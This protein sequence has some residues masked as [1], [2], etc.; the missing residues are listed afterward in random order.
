MGTYNTK[1][2][3]RRSKETNT[4]FEDID[5]NSLNDEPIDD[6]GFTYD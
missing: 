3:L 4:N 5:H 1:E 2:K 6:D